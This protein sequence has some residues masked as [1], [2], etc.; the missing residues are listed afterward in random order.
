MLCVSLFY[1]Q[2]QLA[3]WCCMYLPYL[4]FW[5]LFQSRNI[6][7][8]IINALFIISVTFFSKY[9]LVASQY[10]FIGF[11]FYTFRLP[12]LFYYGW[13]WVIPSLFVLVLTLCPS[14]SLRK[15]NA[16]TVCF[17]NNTLLFFEVDFAYFPIMLGRLNARARFRAMANAS[18]P[19]SSFSL[20]ETSTSQPVDIDRELQL[21]RIWSIS[22]A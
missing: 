9:C 11:G 17:I 16:C 20:G 12:D 15:C 2:F 18:I 8:R 22:F 10:F 19:L 13:Q 21:V 14:Q 4:I 5:I 1:G 3:R 7:C 6:E